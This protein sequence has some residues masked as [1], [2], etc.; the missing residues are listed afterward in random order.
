MTGYADTRGAS[1]YNVSLR[2]ARASA[3]AEALRAKGVK[4]AEAAVVGDDLKPV[5]HRLPSSAWAVAA[6]SAL[7]GQLVDQLGALQRIEGL[8]PVAGLGLR[9]ARRLE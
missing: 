2:T 9:G 6:V 5:A 3:V 7:A 4:V 1:E 8:D